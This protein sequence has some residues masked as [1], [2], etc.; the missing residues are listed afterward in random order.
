MKKFMER[1]TTERQPE[2]LGK[3]ED[4]IEDLE[5]DE[6][7][8]TEPERNN[9]EQI[10]YKQEVETGKRE[11]LENVPQDEEEKKLEQ[12]EKPVVT[13]ADFLDHLENMKIESEN[14][15]EAAL[16]AMQMT[17]IRLALGAAGLSSASVYVEKMP[18]GVLGLYDINSHQ[19]ALAVDLLGAGDQQLIKTVGVHE[20]I[21][22]VEKFYDEGLAQ[23]STAKK[24]SSSS[25]IY[26]EQQ[27]KTRRTFY[28]LGIERAL[29]LYDINDPKKLFENYLQ[30]GLEY[31]YNGQ[32][33]KLKRFIGINAVEKIK[34]NIRLNIEA[35]KIEQGMI[36]GFKKAVPYLY[37][38]LKKYGYDIK[39]NIRSAIKKLA[40]RK[41]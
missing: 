27:D 38:D 33:E 40:V 31:K 3:P 1:N 5:F 9:N 22:K 13:V 35:G 28:R 2:K 23:I 19:I 14:S 24:I 4:S 41:T 10:K 18:S 16:I 21:H 25:G 12:K 7:I 39:T 15:D 8:N 11:V 20:K 34:A 37:K 26:E 32:E 36:A 6:E 30:K 29:K 17:R